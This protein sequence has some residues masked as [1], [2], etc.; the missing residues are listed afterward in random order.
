M[1]IGTQAEI[2]I[3]AELKRSRVREY[4]LQKGFNGLLIS[5]REHFAWV[6]GG[7]DSHV[8]CNSNI[9]FGTIVITKG[10]SWLVAHSMDAARLYEEQAARQGYELVTL[11]WYD[12]DVREKAR[13]LAGKRIASDTDFEGVQNVYADLVDL[14]YPMTEL[15]ISRIRWLASQTDK[16][17]TSF[18]HSVKP[19]ETEKDIATKLHS[20]HLKA[21][22]EVDVLIVGSDERCF[23]YRH[24]IA[25]EKP[26]EKYLMLHT[27]ARRW[28][29]HCN[30]TRFLHFGQPTDEV[31]KVYDA[32]ANV[33]ARVFLSLKPGVKFADILALQKQWYAEQGYPE[34]WRNHFQGGPTGYVIVDA[35]RCLTDKVVQ[36]NQPYEWFITVTGTKM[37]ELSLMTENGLEIL[38]FLKSTWPGMKVP[39]PMGELVVPGL[40]IL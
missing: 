5:T 22:M 10:K 1:I 15:E 11:R 27:V 9:G 36:I 17:F 38:S 37:G 32:A 19:G 16:L 33:E 20:E 29:L 25:T 26:L 35:G 8:V 2:L 7:G 31:R 34:E 40:L 28:G 14:H 24:P 4:L 30:L 23:N 39:T 6:T 3:D 13:Q 21:G 12:G 18:A